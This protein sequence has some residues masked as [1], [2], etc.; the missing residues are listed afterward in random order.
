[1]VLE[2]IVKCARD[3]IGLVSSYSDPNVNENYDERI[4]ELCRFYNI[5]FMPWTK[6]KNTI[7][8]EIA[9]RDINGIVAIGWQYL[10]SRAVF[11]NL[12][13][14]LIV[15]HDSLLPRYRGFA[16][17]VTGMIKGETE[18]GVSVLYAADNIDDGDII[19]QARVDIGSEVYINE[20][21]DQ[22]GQLYRAAAAELCASLRGGAIAAYPQDHSKATYSIWRNAEDCAIDWSKPAIEIYNLIRA[23]SHPYPGAFSILG[24]KLVRIW[25]CRTVEDDIQF[26]IRDPG[27]VWRVESGKPVVVCGCGLLQITDMTD[28]DGQS[29][30]PLT[31]LRV[32]FRSS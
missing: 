15:F 3:C 8:E 13:H 21:I 9:S 26:E 2:E 11:G 32:R 24:G 30:L 16:P 27:K 20:A 5:N 17:V 19:H 7:K 29:L 1:M 12:P 10:V 22:I 23:V 6:L 14:R 31:R 18:F 4:A 28:D 25:R